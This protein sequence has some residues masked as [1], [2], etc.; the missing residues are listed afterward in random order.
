V[1]SADGFPS[2]KTYRSQE[3]YYDHYNGI[4]GG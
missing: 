4:D 2:Q 3:D 1:T